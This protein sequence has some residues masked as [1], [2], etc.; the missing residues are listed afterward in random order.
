MSTSTRMLVFVT[1]LGAMPAALGASEAL[2]Q[3]AA[4]FDARQSSIAKG[5]VVRSATAAVVLA[6][7]LGDGSLAVSRVDDS[8]DGRALVVGAG[9]G[10]GIGSL[11]SVHAGVSRAWW[12]HSED[13][14]SVS[15]GP[16]VH[17]AGN[18]IGARLSRTRFDGGSSVH[19]VAGDFEHTLNARWTA[20]ADAS[21]ARRTDGAIARA[22]LAGARFRVVGP[23]AVLGEVGA[24]HDPYGVLGDGRGADSGPSGLVGGL[25]N[26]NPNAPGNAPAAGSSSA[27]HA[28]AIVGLRCV[29]P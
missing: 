3:P 29:V 10:V 2:A 22:F 5:R 20:R 13:A 14:W 4:A 11:A 8:V 23:L 18:A 6:G 15:A 19:G 27:L 25:L 7:P 17:F 9:A 1:L 26:G 16:D 21:Y 12:D 24:T 28:T